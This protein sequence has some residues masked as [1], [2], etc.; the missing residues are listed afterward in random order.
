M[1]DA[2]KADGRYGEDLAAAFFVSKGFRIVDRNWNHRLGELDL[3]VERNGQV[4]FVEVKYRHTLMFG[5]PEE[6]ITG[7]KLRHMERAIQCWLEQQ[8]SP[9]MDYQ[10]D[11]L[12]I[13]ALPGQKV[14][15]WWVENLF[16]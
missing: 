1:N 5:N 12:A 6:A 10:A 4:R 15:Y 13:T 16:G 2:R 7:K 14:E 9:P 11:A 3:I 8:T